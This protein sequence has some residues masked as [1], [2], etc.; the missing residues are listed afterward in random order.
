MWL[1]DSWKDYEVLDTSAGE[2][3]EGGESISS[4]ARIRR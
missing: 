2:K 1:A 3:L 4:C